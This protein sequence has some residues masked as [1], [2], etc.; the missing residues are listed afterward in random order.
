MSN[1]IERLYALEHPLLMT[2]ALVFITIARSKSKKTNDSS[3]N[4][5]VFVLFVLALACMLFCLPP[6]WL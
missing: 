1:A 4:K 3:M 6:S 5:T 2:V